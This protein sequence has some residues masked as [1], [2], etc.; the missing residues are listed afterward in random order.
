MGLVNK[1]VPDDQ[2]DAEVETWC[3]E[4]MDRS[5]TA[6]AI[7][8]RSFNADSDSI[9]GIGALGMQA[10]RLYYET[11]EIEGR[12]ACFQRE[13]KTGIPQIREVN[14]SSAGFRAGRD[15]NRSFDTHFVPADFTPVAV[16]GHNPSRQQARPNAS[17]L[18]RIRLPSLPPDTPF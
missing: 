13:A 12:R 10:L 15:V 8:K 7:A 17:F 6:M 9:A 3:R 5:P 2:L 16:I 11:E 1:V 18:S 14:E 4:I